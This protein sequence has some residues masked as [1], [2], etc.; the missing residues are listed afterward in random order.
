M[1]K[2]V[3][4]R[5]GGSATATAKSTTA[6]SMLAI[7]SSQR[8]RHQGNSQLRSELAGS[9]TLLA[10]AS[11]P[12]SVST[13]TVTSVTTAA[14]AERSSLALALTEHATGRSVRSLLLDVGSGNDL[15]GEVKPLAEVVETLGGQGV[16][17]VLPRE[18]SLDIAARVERLH[19]LD[20]EQVLGVDIGVLGKV[21][22]LL[23]D[24]D[25]LTE[26]V[27]RAK[28]L[29]MC[30]IAIVSVQLAIR[31]HR[32]GVARKYWLLPRGSSCGRPWESTSWRYLLLVGR[33]DVG[34]WQFSEGRR[35][36]LKMS[37]FVGGNPTRK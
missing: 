31:R 35:Q 8:S 13:L 12:S 27:L 10:L 20:N 4:L 11:I 16:V 21:E 37:T 1:I 9:T 22:V 24:E 17:V 34:R 29:V 28:L 5:R 26:E 25:T 14:T 15:S 23:G 2:W 32:R 36:G 3:R 18:L 19:S 6:S 30:A 7:D 33:V